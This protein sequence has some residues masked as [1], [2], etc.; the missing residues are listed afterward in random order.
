MPGLP[1]EAEGWTPILGQIRLE[2]RGWGE[3]WVL[4][5]VSVTPPEDSA[6]FTASCAWEATISEASLVP[7]KVQNILEGPPRP[8][9]LIGGSRA[10]GRAQQ[11]R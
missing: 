9:Q 4:V 8:H 2:A 3:P 6:T 10:A 5:S 1:H 7:R 11:L